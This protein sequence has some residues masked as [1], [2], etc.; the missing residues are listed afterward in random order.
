MG[1]CSATLIMDAV[2]QAADALMESLRTHSEPWT[3][4]ELEA[5]DEVLRPFVATIAE[6]LRDEDWD[7]IEEADAFDRFRQEML[8]YDDRQMVEYYRYDIADA[9]DSDTVRELSALLAKHLEA[10]NG[11]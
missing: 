9:D 10:L 7:C 5:R 2:T 4:E 3:E 11:G 8:G 6:Q 1:W